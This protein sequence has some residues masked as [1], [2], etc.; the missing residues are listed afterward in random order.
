MWH[1]MYISQIYNSHYILHFSNVVRTSTKHEAY[2]MKHVACSEVN[3]KV[4][5]E[6]NYTFGTPRMF[7]YTTQYIGGI[8]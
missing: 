2:S 7:H 5:L 4:N 3:Q 6:V 1:R 8:S